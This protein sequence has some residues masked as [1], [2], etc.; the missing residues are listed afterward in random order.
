MPILLLQR[1]ARV[2]TKAPETTYT[3]S[4]LALLPLFKESPTTE[5]ILIS[6]KSHTAKPTLT[7][8]PFSWVD[9]LK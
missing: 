1:R 5:K 8:S 2:T 9:E 4:L 3:T 7:N 6:N